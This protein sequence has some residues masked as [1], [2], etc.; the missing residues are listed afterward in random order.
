MCFLS[1]NIFFCFITQRNFKENTT[2]E[3]LYHISYRCV[4]F[5]FIINYLFFFLNKMNILI[6]VE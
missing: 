6:K 1:K 3:L 2:N 5:S 4:D